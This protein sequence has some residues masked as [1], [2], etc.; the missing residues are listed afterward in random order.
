M[1]VF[2]AWVLLAWGLFPPGGLQAAEKAPS[3][4]SLVNRVLHP[5]PRFR[6]ALRAGAKTTESLEAHGKLYT[7]LYFEL[8]LVDPQAEKRLRQRR[9]ERENLL[10]AI[11]AF[12]S[13]L[14]LLSFKRDL[15]RY[16]RERLNH[17]LE[18]NDPFLQTKEEILKL[19]GELR[20]LEA[21]LKAYG[22]SP[23]EARRCRW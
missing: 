8:P 7:G 23:Q 19:E 12:K 16:H 2:L 17:A 21:R 15:L 6:L 22:I 5:G 18:D 9:R 13:S 20:Q 1:L 11:A 3:C 10:K 4:E 14:K